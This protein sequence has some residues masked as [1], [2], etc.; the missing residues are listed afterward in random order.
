MLSFLV[1][2]DAMHQN[3]WLAVLEDLG[4]VTTNLPIP[5]TFPMEGHV[6]AFD[7][8]FVTTNIEA[9]TSQTEDGQVDHLS[10][11]NT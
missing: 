8:G 5:N 2:R 9:S 3:Q 11:S 4:G 1:T 7:Y 10:A 6:P